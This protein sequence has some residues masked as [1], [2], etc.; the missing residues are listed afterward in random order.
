VK[1]WRGGPANEQ[2]RDNGTPSIFVTRDTST[3]ATKAQ[4]TRD[5]KATNLGQLKFSSCAFPQG[6]FSRT[7]GTTTA[8]ASPPVGMDSRM[9]FQSRSANR[10]TQLWGRLGHLGHSRPRFP[11]LPPF[12]GGSC[13]NAYGSATLLPYVGAVNSPVLPIVQQAI[14]AGGDP[15]FHSGSQ[16]PVLRQGSWARIWSARSFFRD[17]N[18]KFNSCVTSRTGEFQGSVFRLLTPRRVMLTPQATLFFRAQ[19]CAC[20]TTKSTSTV[21]RPHDPRLESNER[22]R[23]WGHPV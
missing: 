11:D 17:A 16:F 23:T 9:S 8:Q 5:G 15:Y 18:L 7:E 10:R 2:R 14:N 4:Q 19:E 6:R 12:C 3:S 1:G 13:F 22:A 21:S 20:H